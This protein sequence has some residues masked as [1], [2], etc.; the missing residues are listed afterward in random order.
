MFGPDERIAT[1]SL[2]AIMATHP[3]F[4]IVMGFAPGDGATA[5]KAAM[6]DAL[7]KAV[8]P[9]TFGHYRLA[10]HVELSTLD[11]GDTG[12]TIEWRLA[13]AKGQWLGS[14]TQ[15]GAT[16]PSRIA[17]Y[18]GDFAKSAAEPAAEGIRALIV[19]ANLAKARHQ[20]NAS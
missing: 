14:V 7:M 17:T 4:D 3:D 12:I 20:G 15:K 19:P 6:E 13:T 11:T 9:G 10:G 16:A 18:W 1:T 8:P 5:L 2:A